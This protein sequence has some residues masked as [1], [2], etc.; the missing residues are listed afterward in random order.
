MGFLILER[1]H[2]ADEEQHTVDGG[3]DALGQRQFIGFGHDEL[4]VVVVLDEEGAR[5]DEHG[6]AD[7]TEQDLDTLVDRGAQRLGCLF[8]KFKFV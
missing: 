3:Q 5:G 8:G 6:G 7:Q 4:D 2:R 1:E